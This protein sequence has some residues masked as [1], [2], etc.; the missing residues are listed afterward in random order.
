MNSARPASNGRHLPKNTCGYL[1]TIIARVHADILVR[2]FWVQH[3]SRPRA[4]SRPQSFVVVV[5]K[6]IDNL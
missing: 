4:A 3:V 2:A 6:K 1:W 5:A